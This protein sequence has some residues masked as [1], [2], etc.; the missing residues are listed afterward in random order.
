M[1]FLLHGCALTDATLD[2]GLDSSPIGRGPLSEI[3]EISFSLGD[4]A[5]KREDTERVGYKKDGFGQS[6]GSINSARPVTT[7]VRDVIEA[8]VVANGHNLGDSG[9]SVSGAVDAF[10]LETD[11]SSSK[12]ELMCNINVDLGFADAITGDEIYSNSYSASYSDKKQMA[13]EENL[14]E[15]IDRALHALADEIVSDAELSEALAAR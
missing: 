11:T 6:K 8:A 10:W 1:G 14:T 5:D 9:V 7:V 15:I 3:E 12:I 4:L 2:V 13:T